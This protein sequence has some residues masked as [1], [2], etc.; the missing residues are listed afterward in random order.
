[1]ATIFCGRRNCKDNKCGVCHNEETNFVIG[2][3][4]KIDVQMQDGC[5]GFEFDQEKWMRGEIK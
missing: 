1:M 2:K 5:L 3:N 4:V